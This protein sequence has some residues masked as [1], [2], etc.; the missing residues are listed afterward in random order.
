MN[1]NQDVYTFGLRRLAFPTPVIAAAEADSQ[2]AFAR[3]WRPPIFHSH[4]LNLRDET[5][6]AFVP[7]LAKNKCRLRAQQLCCRARYRR[8][9]A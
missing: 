4:A 8:E 5:S 1:T 3:V 9:H 7:S 2:L 6:L